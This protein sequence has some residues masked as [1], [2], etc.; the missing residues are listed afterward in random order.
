MSPA[1]RPTCCPA[2]RQ[3]PGEMSRHKQKTRIKWPLCSTLEWNVNN[4]SWTS[5][6]LLWS[7]QW[8]GNTSTSQV[9]TG[10]SRQIVTI[11]F[12]WGKKLF[13]GLWIL[14]Y[15]L[16]IMQCNQ[17]NDLTNELQCQPCLH[18]RLRELN[19]RD[20]VAVCSLRSNCSEDWWYSGLTGVWRG[21]SWRSPD[22]KL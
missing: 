20:C 21:F 6:E 14:I 13:Q 11:V 8:K 4:L 22:M 5:F 12:T 16:K 7:N 17:W 1:S 19:Q 18:S 10:K 9:G 3:D 15:T 2:D